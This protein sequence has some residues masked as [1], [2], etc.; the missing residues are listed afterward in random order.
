MNPIAR[1]AKDFWTGIIYIVV[2]GAAIILGRDYG[3]GTAMKMGSAYFPVILSGLL[4]LIGSLSVIRSFIKPGTPVGTVAWKGL[5]MIIGATVL[6]GF[7]VRGA[8][9][10][11][12]LPLLVIISAYASNR[13]SWKYALALAAGVT[14]FCILVFQ[15]GLGVPLPI[16]GSWFGD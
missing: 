16:F 5:T 15:V 11:I 2:G 9:M 1:N 14:V 12:A 3:L 8:G 7:I 10:A 4:I 6:F 13:F